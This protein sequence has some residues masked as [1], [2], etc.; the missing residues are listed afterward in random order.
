MVCRAHLAMELRHASPRWWYVS[1]PW[2][3]SEVHLWSR[4][5]SDVR[6]VQFPECSKSM[7]LSD[8]Y[9]DECSISF[10]TACFAID[11][12]SRAVLHYRSIHLFRSTRSGRCTRPHLPWMSL[13]VICLMRTPP[14]IWSLLTCL[15]RYSQTGYE[16][17]Q[18]LHNGIGSQFVYSLL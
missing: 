14:G 15:L 8:I 1:P 2:T 5:E 17:G 3:E 6:G 7:G 11:G 9:S 12:T 18:R 13:L 16:T 4:S 10:H